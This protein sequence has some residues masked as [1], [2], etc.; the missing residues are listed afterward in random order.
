MKS[1][2]VYV[3]LAVLTLILTAGVASV[4]AYQGDYTK[5]GPNTDP[6]R[7][8]AMQA[9]L[10]GNDYNSWK[11]LMNDKGR[12]AQV[13]NEE[14]FSQF[15]EARR[16]GQSGDKTG[17][18]ALR[19]ELGLR[20]SN[21]E[22]MNASFKGGNGEGRGQGQGQGQRGQGTKGSNGSGNF[23]DSNGDGECDYLS[24]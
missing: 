6:E 12:V 3:S 15:A 22:K 4:S 21:G 17:A 14:N 23:M 20:G 18:D 13:V 19:A 5:Q 24:N 11:G 16:L 10:D 8:E 1:K 9:A 2:K 7:H